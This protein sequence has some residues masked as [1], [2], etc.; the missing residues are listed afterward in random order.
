MK[1]AAQKVK[2]YAT[3]VNIVDNHNLQKRILR[4]LLVSFGFLALAYVFI[5]GNIIF[6]VVERQSLGGETKTL[7]SE[8]G[9]LEL[10]YLSISGKIDLALSQEMGFKEPKTNF[11]VRKSL[12]ALKLTSNEL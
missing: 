3:N 7:S 5:L 10:E 4:T 2:S 8:V 1:K 6:N 12:S 11:A 9:N